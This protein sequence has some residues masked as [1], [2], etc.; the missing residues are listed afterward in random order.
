[1]VRILDNPTFLGGHRSY[2]LHNLTARL[3]RERKR[4]LEPAQSFDDLVEDLRGQVSKEG[5]KDVVVIGE[6]GKDRGVHSTEK[7]LGPTKTL[8]LWDF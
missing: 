5:S 3:S 8:W 7:I 6:L 2:R 4:R 1:M